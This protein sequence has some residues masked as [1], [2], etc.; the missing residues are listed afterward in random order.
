MSQHVWEMVNWGE[1]SH[2]YFVKFTYLEFKTK[3]NKD[4]YLWAVTLKQVQ[5][6]SQIASEHG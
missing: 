4:I 3:W 6:H 1:E 5:F 2:F